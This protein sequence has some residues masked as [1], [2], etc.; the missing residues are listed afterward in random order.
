MM[1]IFVNILGGILILAGVYAVFLGM[2]SSPENSNSMSVV[3]G[4]GLLIALGV[5]RFIF[6]RDY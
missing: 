6:I 5:Y 4:G 3:I 1:R 2:I